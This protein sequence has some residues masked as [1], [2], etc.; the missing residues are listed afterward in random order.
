MLSPVSVMLL[1]VKN[2]VPSILESN[3]QEY[4]QLGTMK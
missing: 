3:F 2:Y 1:A 4:M